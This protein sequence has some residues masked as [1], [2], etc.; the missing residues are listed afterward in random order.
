MLSVSES[1][2]RVCPSFLEMKVEACEVAVETWSI[3]MFRQRVRLI[4]CSRHLLQFEI[5]CPDFIFAP[6]VG[7]GKMSNLAEA[8]PPADANG[9]RSICEHCQGQGQ[10]EIGA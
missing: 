3:N 9:G 5:P 6:Q 2:S 8:A 4:L 1:R 10:P 7:H